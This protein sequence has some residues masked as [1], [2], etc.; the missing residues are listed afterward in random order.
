MFDAIVFRGCLSACRVVL[1]FLEVLAA[2]GSCGARS[3]VDFFMRKSAM[4]ESGV[5]D[6]DLLSAWFLPW[7]ELTVV[8]RIRYGLYS[9]IFRDF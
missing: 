9:V 1:V 3:P 8:R 6:P 5:G 2:S 4:L 7:C